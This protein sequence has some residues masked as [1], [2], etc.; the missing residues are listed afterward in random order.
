[1]LKTCFVFL[2]CMS[3]NHRVTAALF[4]GSG[5]LRVSAEQNGGLTKEKYVESP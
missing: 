5:S 2:K 4:N 3:S 1:L